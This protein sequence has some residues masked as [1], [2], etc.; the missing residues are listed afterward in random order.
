MAHTYL[1]FEFGNDEEKAQQVRHKLESLKAAFKLDKKMLLKFDRKEDG[2]VPAV[3]EPAI[4]EK[5][6]KAAEAKG[7][8]AKAGKGPKKADPEPA[9]LA[10]S[11]AEIKLILRVALPNHEKLT[12]QR[13]FKRISEDETL[14]SVSPKTVRHADAGFSELDSR[15]EELE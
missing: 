12:E 9:K 4:K 15:F 10:S 2:A 7:K 11:K 1:T 13:L 14:K 6:G 3:A 8:D 5:A